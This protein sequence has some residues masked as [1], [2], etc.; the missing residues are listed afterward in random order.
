MNNP[1]VSSR[2]AWKRLLL[3]G[4]CGLLVW[5]LYSSLRESARR[6][7]FVAVDI[8]GMQHMGPNFNIAQF[9]LDGVNGFNVGREGGGGS[10]VCCVLLPREWRPGLSVDLRWGINDWSEEIPAEISAG[11]YGSVTSGGVYR[12]RVPVEKY[13][14]TGTVIVHFFA[15]GKARVVVGLPGPDELSRAILPDDSRAADVA[16]V[17]QRFEDLFSKE[18]RDAMHR[19]EDERKRKF[20]GDWR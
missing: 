3:L 9:F 8:D 12:A 13:D 1:G 10:S 19:R 6:D 14:A 15:G 20:G 7:A 11:N 5:W 4:L 18:E 2:T 16:T 17:G